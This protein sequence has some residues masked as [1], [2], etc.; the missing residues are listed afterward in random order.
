MNL[1]EEFE[2]LKYYDARLKRAFFEF[3]IKELFNINKKLIDENLLIPKNKIAFLES[4]NELL[5][6]VVINAK[7]SK[8]GNDI[9]EDLEMKINSQLEK[10]NY[11][12]SLLSTS[13]KN[14]FNNLSSL[15]LSWEHELD[16]EPSN[17][18]ATIHGFIPFDI[19]DAS[20][21]LDRDKYEHFSDEEFLNLNQEFKSIIRDID[22]KNILSVDLR[23]AYANVLLPK[24]YDIIFDVKNPS[25][26]W[27]KKTII[28][29]AF[30]YRDIFHTELWR[31]HSSH[32]L[33]EI[34]GEIPEIIKELPYISIK[35]HKYHHGIGFC[36]EY[37]WNYIK[38]K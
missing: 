32:C 17:R 19:Y 11:Y 29:C 36:T 2:S 6:T 33:I 9:I 3:L 1:K 15:E 5:H 10:E 8:I 12:S 30:N 21:S 38:N 34:I 24:A 20:K 7:L 14:S 4:S 25:R 28:K 26:Y 27:K 18:F 13:I 31:G 35:D 16:I 22:H 37:D 23:Y